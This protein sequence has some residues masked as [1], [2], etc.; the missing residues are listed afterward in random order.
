M[1]RRVTILR[2]PYNERGARVL[3]QVADR[4]EPQRLKLGGLET[5]NVV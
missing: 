1:Y 4:Q 3:Q 2:F 5:A